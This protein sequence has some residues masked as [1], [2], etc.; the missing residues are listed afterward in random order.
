MGVARTFQVIQL[1]NDLTVF[2]N[3]LV[4]THVHNR[5]GLFSNVAASAATLAAEREAREQVEQVLERLG[6]ADVAG[7]RARGLP[8]G[9]LR[10]VEL[11]RAIVTEPKV[12]MLDEPASGLNDAETDHLTEVIRDVRALGVAVLLI[13]HDVRMVT[14]VSEHVYVLDQ[15]QIISEGPPADVR[16]DPGVIAAYLGG[17]PE[18]E[19]VH[20]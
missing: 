17:A 9:V 6:L 10:M 20:A 13:E 14:S 3:L 19:E 5:S 7:Q 11:G 15:G 1:F 2:D 4:A 16:R 8:F 12:M 18:P